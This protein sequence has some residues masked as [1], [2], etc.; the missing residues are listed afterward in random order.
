MKRRKILI[1][2]GCGVIGGMLLTAG[3]RVLAL[4]N[5]DQDITAAQAKIDLMS[6]GVVL[7]EKALLIRLQRANKIETDS[8][9]MA[10]WALLKYSL[11]SLIW[12][13]ERITKD[14]MTMPV[15]P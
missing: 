7:G 8:T 13:R 2:I 1:L 11:D 15:K 10:E 5:R 4:Y 14:T 3:I 6:R 9:L 12:E